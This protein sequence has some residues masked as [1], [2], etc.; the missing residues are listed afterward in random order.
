MEAVSPVSSPSLSHEKGAKLLQDAEKGHGEHDLRQKQQGSLKASAPEA[1]HLQHLRQPDG[2]Q[3]QPLQSSQ[4]IKGMNQR[5]VTLAQHISVT[6]QPRSPPSPSCWGS[7]EEGGAQR[8]ISGGDG[9]GVKPQLLWLGAGE[10]GA[11]REVITQDYT[12]HHPQQLNSHIQ[13]PVYS[14]PGATCPVLDLRRT[15][16]EA[17]LQQEHAAASRISP[18]GEGGKR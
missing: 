9:R 1:A 4:S 7:R 10:Q 5:V 12:R 3:C 13:P 8:N 2:P 6:N 11:S 15:P 14:F 18:Q 17:Y 16:S